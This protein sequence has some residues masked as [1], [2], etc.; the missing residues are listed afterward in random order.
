MINVY[1]AL[2]HSYLR[3]GIFAWGCAS[4]SVLEPLKVLSNRV[5]KIMTFAPFGN[6]PLNPIFK[7]LEILDIP[8]IF[9]HETAKFL[10]KVKNNLLPCSIGNYFPMREYADNHEFNHERPPKIVCR[11]VSSEKSL[12]HREIELWNSIPNEI[13]SGLTL[14]SFKKQ[15]KSHLL[16]LYND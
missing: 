13:K 6:V 7:C 3:Y 12:Q 8:Q 10:F 11:L 9:D 15:F 4:S 1:Y 16:R 5:V 14:H 2:V